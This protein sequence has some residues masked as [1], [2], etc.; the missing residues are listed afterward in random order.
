MSWRR[1]DWTQEYELGGESSWLP[2]DLRIRSKAD[3]PGDA[4]Y[5][6]RARLVSGSLPR[7][8]SVHPWGSLDFDPRA[9]K[10]SVTR[11]RELC[12]Q[13]PIARPPHRG[14]CIVAAT[15][16]KSRSAHRWNRCQ[17]NE[18][19]PVVLTTLYTLPARQ[20]LVEASKHHQKRC[21]GS[22]R[23]GPPTTTG[24]AIP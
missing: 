14:T 19:P 2:F 12:R 17:S 22:S 23:P 8:I 6:Q 11:W 16:R 21:L 9:E 5:N 1:L 15:R 18:F 13:R 24:G 10:F 3:R 20:A 4:N 7:L